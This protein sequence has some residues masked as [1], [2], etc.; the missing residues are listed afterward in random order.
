MFCIVEVWTTEN[1][2][3]LGEEVTTEA[4]AQSGQPRRHIGR[5]QA[6]AL[7]NT[8]HGEES[9]PGYKV[10]EQAEGDTFGFVIVLWQFLTQVAAGKGADGEENIVGE[11]QQEAHRVDLCA[12]KNYQMG[13]AL[14]FPGGQW[15]PQ[16]KPHETDEQVDRGADSDKQTGTMV[17][18][19]SV[20]EHGD[21]GGKLEDDD[22]LEGADCQAGEEDRKTERKEG[23][24]Q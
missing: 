18:G 16:C 8:G 23:L 19:P 24:T 11:R 12:L 3:A 1:H 5:G 13:E 15:G 2:I 7:V 6:A 21:L 14:V 22:Q 4:A 20:V 17:L 9:D 10:E